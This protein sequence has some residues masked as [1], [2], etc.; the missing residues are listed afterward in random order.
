MTTRSVEGEMPPLEL[1]ETAHAEVTRL[2]EEG[3]RLESEGSLDGALAKY[4]EGLA[5]LPAPMTNW[6][7]ATW[8]LSAIGDLEFQKGQF[9]SAIRALEKALQCPGGLGNPFI[10]LRLGECL[11]EV[12]NQP[13]A[14]DEL[15]RAYMGAGGE[16]FSGEDPKYFQALRKVLKPPAGAMSL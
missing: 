13:A 6:E 10:H 5:L 11:F 16:I 8:L 9:D 4:R 15:A 1:S 2:S 12:G 3:G 14:M 7:A